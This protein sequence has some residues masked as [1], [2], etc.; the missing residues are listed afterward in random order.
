MKA[1]TTLSCFYTA[2]HQTAYTGHQFIAVKWLGYVQV[3]AL[4]QSPGPVQWGIL[5]RQQNNWDMLARLKT[6]EFST[7]LKTVLFRQN[8]I[9]TIHCGR[10]LITFSTASSPSMAVTTSKPL[11][12]NGVT[13]IVNSV[14]LSSTTSIFCP[15]ILLYLSNESIMPV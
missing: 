6:F 9:K 11:F 14:Q 12:R 8:N 7:Q 3:C 10:S 2:L 5:T 1:R 15:G 13:I 4:S